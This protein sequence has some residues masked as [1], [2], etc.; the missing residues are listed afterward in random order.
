M[1]A[2]PRRAPHLG[3]PRL[4]PHLADPAAVGVAIGVR[5]PQSLKE[6]LP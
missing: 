4:P 3:P 6:G 1:S 5:H 2:L